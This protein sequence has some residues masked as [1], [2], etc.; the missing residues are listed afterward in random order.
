MDYKYIHYCTLSGSSVDDLPF[1]QDEEH[2]DCIALKLAI[3]ERILELHDHGISDFFANCELGL[4]L[5]AA[6]AV[7]AS[8]GLRPN[9]PPRLHVVMPHERQ[10]NRWSADIQER[11]Y[12]LHE[13]AESVTMLRTQYTVDCYSEADDFMLKHSVVLLADGGNTELL[14]HAKTKN[15]HIERITTPTR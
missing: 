15:K 5:W 14:N 1:G 11:F 4:P 9:E 12:N 7:I 10:A 2:P 13:A 8:R 6:K 3:G